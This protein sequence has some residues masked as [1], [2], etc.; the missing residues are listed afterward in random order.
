MANIV[1]IKRSTTADA[2]PL[3]GDLTAGELAI[4]TTDGNLFYKNN[5]GSVTVIASNKFVTVTGNVTGGN[6][7]TSGLISA[8]GNITSVGNVAGGNIL[9]VNFRA[10]GIFYGDGSGLSGITTTGGYFSSTLTSFPTGDYGTGEPYVEEGTTQDAFGVTI[11]S[12]FSCQ[13]PQGSVVTA[14]DLG[15]L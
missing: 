15:V 9:G 13:D 14:T 2:V 12:N 5:A 11:V 7:L 3:V 6:L 4:N 1:L 8:T 10:T